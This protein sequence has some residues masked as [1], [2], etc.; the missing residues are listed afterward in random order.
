M[1]PSLMHYALVTAQRDEQKRRG[2]RRRHITV[3]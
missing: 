1:N 3:R 2:R